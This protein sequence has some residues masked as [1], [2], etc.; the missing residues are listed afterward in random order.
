VVAVVCMTLH[1]ARFL[2]AACRGVCWQAAC[3]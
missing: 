1:D 3:R 2:W